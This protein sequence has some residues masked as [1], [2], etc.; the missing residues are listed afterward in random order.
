MHK[1]TLNPKDASNSGRGHTAPCPLDHCTTRQLHLRSYV[2]LIDTNC[3]HSLEK[4][5]EAC[6]AV[7]SLIQAM[8]QKNHSILDV[9]IVFVDE[10]VLNGGGF[11][12]LGETDDTYP[13]KIHKPS[14]CYYQSC[15]WPLF[16]SA[17]TS[18]VLRFECK[19]DIVAFCRAASDQICNAVTGT[20]DVSQGAIRKRML[21]SNCC[22]LTVHHDERLDMQ[23]TGMLQRMWIVLL[24]LL[25]RLVFML[26]WQQESIHSVQRRLCIAR[27]FSLVQ[28][29]SRNGS[30]HHNTASNTMERIHVPVH[31]SSDV[32]TCKAFASDWARG[33]VS[34]LKGKHKL[35]LYCFVIFRV[36]EMYSFHVRKSSELS[37]L[38]VACSLFQL[39]QIVIHDL[40]SPV[41]NLS[42]VGAQRFDSP[43][44]YCCCCFRPVFK[45][46][47]LFVLVSYR[48]I[49]VSFMV[50]V[51]YWTLPF[52]AFYIAAFAC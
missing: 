5:K 11:Y 39:V 46:F 35:L 27:Y 26:P 13:W 8:I 15:A 43:Y 16:A 49:W 47:R 31:Y 18:I 33:I 22:H 14:I 34:C 10:M 48:V 51:S 41:A 19:E 24:V 45:F 29:V 2:Y 37:V 38:Y 1:R 36:L 42:S 40:V 52:A 6:N 25:S 50:L 30:P 44:C 4:K 9:T 28:C 7:L 21:A 20:L 23:N 3:I 17:Q 32:Q 12:P